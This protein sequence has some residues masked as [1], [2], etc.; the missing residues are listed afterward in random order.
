M[1]QVVRGGFVESVHRGL[2]I[3]TDATGE[4]VTAHGDPGTVVLPRS[5]LKPIQALAFLDA[6]AS[7]EGSALALASAS[8]AGEPFHL[9]QVRTMLAGVGLTPDALQNTPAYPVADRAREDWIRAGLGPES[10]TQNCSGKHAGMVTACVAA[11]WPTQTYLELTHPLQQ[12]IVAFVEQVTGESIVG[13]VVDGCGAPAHA[14]PMR[15][16]ARAFGRLAAAQD[17]PLRTIADA[18]RAWPDYVGGP[19][20]PDTELMRNAP[21]VVAKIG[22]E[23]IFVAGLPSGHG[24]AVKIA[25]G[26][27]RASQVVAASLLRGLGVD[28]AACDLLA[29]VPVLGHGDRVGMIR[30]TV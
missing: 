25:D 15:G 4:V 26:A 20:R 29:D 21:G 19:G 16:M 9:E 3:V 17:G 23:G 7:L 24:V 11:G 14:L 30:A 22:A 5:S 27:D 13:S 8:H 28:A 1:A 12:S 6:G 18:M 10:L 2:G